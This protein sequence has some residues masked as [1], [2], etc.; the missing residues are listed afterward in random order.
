[1]SSLK[2]IGTAI[3]I[4]LVLFSNQLVLAEDTVCSYAISKTNRLI[5]NLCSLLNND[6][7]LKNLWKEAKH[8]GESKLIP[9]LLLAGGAIVFAGIAGSNA[10]ANIDKC[11]N[12]LF[13]GNVEDC[14]NNKPVVPFMAIG[15]LLFITDIAVWVWPNSDLRTAINATRQAQNT[16]VFGNGTTSSILDSSSPAN[17]V[18]LKDSNCDEFRDRIAR[19]ECFRKKRSDSKLIQERRPSNE[20]DTTIK[21][22]MKM[23]PTQGI[24]QEILEQ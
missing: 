2:L 10:S 9:G 15:G 18:D 12:S 11:N 19:Y 20:V 24:P 8:S 16:Q 14:F 5:P 3:S 23:E 21:P 7:K 13:E 17:E 6:P 1:M 4:A 22:P